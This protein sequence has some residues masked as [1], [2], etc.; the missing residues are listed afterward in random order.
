MKTK[1]PGW[2]F[3]VSL[4][5][6]AVVGTEFLPDKENSRLGELGMMLGAGGLV[7]YKV[8]QESGRTDDSEDPP[9]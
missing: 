7:G 9:S 5:F 6:V 3:L 1:I 2:V 8:L 4:G